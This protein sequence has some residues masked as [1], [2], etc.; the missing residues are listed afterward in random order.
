MRAKKRIAGFLAFLLLAAMAIMPVNAAQGGQSGSEAV[1]EA[2]NGV[3]QVNLVYVDRNSGAHVIQGGTGFLIGD[4]TGAEYMITNAHVVNMDDSVK[5]AAS[6]VFGVD[7]NNPSNINLQI[8]VVV[9]RDVVINATIVNQSADMDFAILKLEQVIY[10][11]TPL[12]IDDDD[13]DLVETMDVYALGFPAAIEMVEDTPFYVSSDVSI[14]NGIV[15]TKTSIDGIKYIRH[16][17][18]MTEGNSGGPL[19]NRDG[20]VVGVN[21]LG[22]DETYFYSLQ[23]SEVTSVLKALGI[24][25]TSASAGGSAPSADESETE[26]MVLPETPETEAAPTID[27]TALSALVSEVSAMDLSGYDEASSSALNDA[28]ANGQ[29]ALNN[30]GASQED[31]DAAVAAITAAKDGLKEK[32][33]IPMGLII[34]IVAAIA[35]VAVVIIVMMNKNRKPAVESNYNRGPSG[36]SAG[37]PNRSTGGSANV[38]NRSAA[39]PSSYSGPQNRGAAGGAGAGGGETSLL[40]SGAGETSLLGGGETSILGGGA[41]AVAATLVRTKNGEQIQIRKQIFKIGKERVKVDYCI[42]DNNT[43]SRIH[44][45]ITFRNGEYYISDMKSTNFTYVN[46]SKLAEN[47]DMKLRNGDKIKLSDEEFEFRC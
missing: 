20:A 32:A 7:F 37:V 45:Q 42:S 19:V 24:K 17:A 39:G 27:K 35:V 43:I 14:I 4:E 2:R 5:A 22:V 13:S 34:G 18:T 6:D 3:L 11:R 47:Q 33:G 29:I 25:Y 44:A 31:V 30:A 38:P 12:A 8:Q 15:S 23:I 28:L 46:G 40:D 10:D 26:G 21:T 9:K 41:P 1:N 16:G 36:G